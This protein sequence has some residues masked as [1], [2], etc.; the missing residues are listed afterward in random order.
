MVDT[1]ILVIAYNGKRF[2]GWQSQ[3]SNF[4]VQD[5]LI[6]TFKR[7]FKHNLFLH[8]ASRTDSGVHALGQVALCKFN[9][10]GLE[11]DKV[12]AL[13][14]ESLPLDIKIKKCLKAPVNFHPNINV[15]RKI[16]SY[17]LFLK[18]PDPFASIGWYYPLIKKMDKSRFFECLKAFEGKWDFHQFYKASELT[19]V[20]S[21]RSISKIEWIE[22]DHEIRIIFVG[23]SFLRYQIRRIIGAAIEYGINKKINLDDIVESLSGKINNLIPTF[24]AAGEG[25]CLEQIEYEGFLL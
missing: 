10:F 22:S 15:F 18:K 9:N 25:L 17:K 12:I 16:Y 1:Y 13:W 24:C 20:I 11:I 23:K 8:G 3:P 14:N 7:V 4:T 6:K 21:I 5:F 19:K 2:E